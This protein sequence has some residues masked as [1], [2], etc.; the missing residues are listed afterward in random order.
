MKNYIKATFL[1]ALL[2]LTAACAS[3]PI[4]DKRAPGEP[5]KKTYEVLV[6]GQWI[7]VTSE[8]WDNCGMYDPY[9]DCLTQPH[10]G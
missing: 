4:E 7:K 1:A 8:Q 6:D 2:A 3:G 9:P 10:N 5:G